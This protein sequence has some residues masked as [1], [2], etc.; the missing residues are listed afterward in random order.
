MRPVPPV[1]CSLATDP[2]QLAG[3]ADEFRR[4]FAEALIGR[5][6]TSA[7]I[8]FRLRAEPGIE[9]WTRDLAQR[10]HACCPFF[11]FDIAVSDGVVSW[12]ASVI[13]NDIARQVLENLYQL[14]AQ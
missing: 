10:E 12:H 7:G 2:E 5:D 9:E 3:R 8:R 14:A 4:L 13:D 6:R 11:R 1:A